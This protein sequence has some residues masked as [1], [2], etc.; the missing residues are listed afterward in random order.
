MKAA[1]VTGASRGIGRAIAQGLAADGYRLFCVSTTDGGCDATAASCRDAGAEVKTIACDVADAAGVE[2]MAARVIDE[3]GGLHVLVNNA[4]ITRDGL[5]LRMTAEDFDAV[6]A[7]NLRGAFLTSKAFVK[8]MA[9]ARGGR[10]VNIGSVVGVVGNPGQVNYAA[11]K[12][13]LIGLTKALAKE[14][15]SRSVTVNVVAPGFIETDMTADLP[16]DIKAGAK[17]GIP[18]GR[19]GSPEDVAAA[20]RFLCSDAAAYIT[21][22]VLMVDGGMAM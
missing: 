12:A 7:V 9:K 10:I 13:G 17:Q 8:G 6:H 4:G 3:S 1:L 20:V 18:L 22:Q 14:L 2:A 19:F 16:D 15:G 11:S 5:F 21:G